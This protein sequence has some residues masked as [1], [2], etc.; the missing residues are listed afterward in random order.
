MSQFGR[1]RLSTLF[2]QAEIM[3]CYSHWV[4]PFG[5]PRVN[6]SFQLTEDY[7]RYAR[8]SSPVDA[9]ASTSSS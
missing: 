9:K 8:P 6:A 2:I 4:A 3:G 7:R 5:I 1:Y